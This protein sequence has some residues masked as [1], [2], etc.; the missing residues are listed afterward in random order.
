MPIVQ[1]LRVVRSPIHGYGVVALRPFTKG[2]IVIRAE[3]FVYAED[4][5]FDD[6]YALVLPTDDLPGVQGEHIYYDLVDQSRWINHSCDP[7]T[8]VESA[9]DHA[10]GQPSAW[11][12]A[13]RDIRE[14]EELVY[15]YAFV[16]ALAEVCG[17]GATGCRGLIVDP[18]PEELANVPEALRHHLRLD[19]PGLRSVG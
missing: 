1:G 17:C 15:D 19:V 13:T 10:T 18:D 11:W 12:V 3:G 5:S 2:E 9:M 7:N 14:G 4:E 8:E 16:G 6:T